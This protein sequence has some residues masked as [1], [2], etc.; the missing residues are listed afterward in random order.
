MQDAA[1]DM[2][3][4]IVIVVTTLMT[5]CSESARSRP[6]GVGLYTPNR[7]QDMAVGGRGAAVPCIWGES[8]YR[9]NGSTGSCLDAGTC[10]FRR[11]RDNCN[12]CCLH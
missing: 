6:L 2:M 1:S 7:Q 11:A 8:L 12:Q 5:L 10:P 3:M 9:G 4:A